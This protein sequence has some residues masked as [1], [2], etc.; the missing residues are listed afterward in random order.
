MSTPRISRIHPLAGVEGGRVTILGADLCSPDLGQVTPRFGEAE[1]RPL[2]GS[3]TKL[4]APIPEGATS[5]FVVVTW[6]GG[7]SEGP[8]FEIAEKLADELHPVANPVIDKDGRI[9]TTFSGSRGQAPPNGVSVFR[10]APDGTVEPYLSELMNP[11]GLALDAAGIL[12]IS[13]RNDGTV[14]K[15]TAAGQTEV[16]AEGLGIATGMAFAPDGTLFVGDRSGGIYAVAPHGSVRRFAK[17]PASVAAYHLAFG[18]DGRLYVTAPTLAND[19]PIYC[20]TDTGDVS[21]FFEHLARPQGLAFDRDGA[22]FVVAIHAGERG[23]FRIG[24]DGQATLAVAGENL[25]GLAFDSRG[26]MVIATT[27]AIYRLGWT[28]T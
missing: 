17:L 18:P 27:N 20:I 4:V 23:I 9:V 25:V 11:T 22:L 14:H 3:P 5:G 21:R 13:C 8:F 24:T 10:I 6:E 15:V 12:F 1:T 2:I 16:I 7:S 26:R 19:D 28:G